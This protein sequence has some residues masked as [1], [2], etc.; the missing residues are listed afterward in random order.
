MAQPHPT[1]TPGTPP[2]MVPAATTRAASIAQ[3]L[4]PGH[5]LSSVTEKVSTIVLRPGVQL[6]WLL[7][8]LIA[9]AGMNL[10]LFA[11]SVLVMRGTG[12]GA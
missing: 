9:F 5:N 1:E 7:G 10:F 8:F 3:V 11:I 4:E 12:S 2:R 6:G